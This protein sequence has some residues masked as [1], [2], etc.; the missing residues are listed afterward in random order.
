MTDR[1]I[2]SATPGKT[3][4]ID[5]V[6]PQGRPA[7]VSAIE[8]EL[9]QP[10]PG[11]MFRGFSFMLGTARTRRLSIV[12]AATAKKKTAAIEEMVATLRTAGEIL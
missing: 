10:Q 8:G 1:Y 11:S 7:F 2:P 5:V 6:K 9:E 4:S 3:W 12:G